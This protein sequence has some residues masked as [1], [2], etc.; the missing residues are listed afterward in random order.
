MTSPQISRCPHPEVVGAGFTERRVCSTSSLASLLTSDCHGDVLFQCKDSCDQGLDDRGHLR[1]RGGMRGL[2]HHN[3]KPSQQ[4]ASH[5]DGFFQRSHGARTSAEMGQK[6]SVWTRADANG[7]I[8]QHIDDDDEWNSRGLPSG[9]T[10][11]TGSSSFDNAERDVMS[12]FATAGS[13]SA[14]GPDARRKL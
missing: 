4:H 6:D 13:P 12:L 7:E 11:A 10:Y 1:E 9:A 3:S 2:H 8:V 14:P 5:D